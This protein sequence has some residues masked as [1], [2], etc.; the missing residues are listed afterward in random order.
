MVRTGTYQYVPV[1]DGTGQYKNSILVRSSMYRYIP[2]RTFK[3]LSG[4]LTHPER[5]RRDEIRVIHRL[6]MGYNV[7][8]SNFTTAQ[9]QSST[10]TYWYILVYTGTY[11]YILRKHSK[12]HLITLHPPSC[13]YESQQNAWLGPLSHF[14][15]AW[16]SPP[17][18]DHPGE[19]FHG[20]SSTAKC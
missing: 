6:C 3:Q 2:V 8:R 19:A 7:T 12:L 1:R 20:Q 11:W 18:S 9:V 4:F 5:V 15:S 14:S 17:L 10:S 13:A 16:R